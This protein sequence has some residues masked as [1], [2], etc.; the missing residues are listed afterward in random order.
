MHSHTHLTRRPWDFWLARAAVLLV[1]VLQFAV[2]NDF[3]FGP[4]WLA[5]VLEIALLLPLSFATAWTLGKARSTAEPHV[6]EVAKYRRA[7]RSAAMLLTA[8][9]TVMNFAALF[10]LVRALLSGKAGAGPS[11]LLDALNIWATNVI[12]FSLWFW[13]MDRGGPAMRGLGLHRREDFLFPQMSL[14]QLHDE[15]WAPGFVDYL[16]LAFTNATAFSPTD[17]LPLSQRAKLLMMAQAAVSL[18]VVALVAARAVNIL[19]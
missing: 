1:A 4:K 7:I 11:L 14:P 13:N 18:L 19:A 15:E 3:S 12:A 17:T 6:L 5:P 8:L 2:I 10:D 16:F 9:I